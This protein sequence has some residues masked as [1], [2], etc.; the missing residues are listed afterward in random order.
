M[1]SWVVT[2]S[3]AVMVIDSPVPE[4]PAFRDSIETTFGLPVIMVNSHGHIDHI[5]CNAQFSEVYMAKEDWALACGGGIA[6]DPAGY[7]DS[8]L[9]YQLRSETGRYCQFMC[10]GTQEDVMCFMMP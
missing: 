10:R 9:P 2:G 7:Q 5:G 6:P 1:Q 8:K 4:N 3:H